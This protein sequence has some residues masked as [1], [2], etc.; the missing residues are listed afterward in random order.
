MTWSSIL[1]FITISALC[2]GLGFICGRIGAAGERAR[3]LANETADQK[4]AITALQAELQL[5]WQQLRDQQRK[6]AADQAKQRD[7]EQ[8]LATARAETRVVY[9]T[10]RK[11]IP[12]ASIDV[13][14]TVSPGLAGA[15]SCQFGSDF[16][17]VWDD[18][19]DPSRVSA[20][21]AGL[22]GTAGVT[23]A[24]PGGADPAVALDAEQLLS[25]HVDNAE[26]STEARDA[27]NALIDWHLEHDLQ[28]LAP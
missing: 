14:A 24:P 6:A 7:L 25:N 12:N 15:G 11:E 10:I 2:L 21:A 9:R 13:A 18:A 22:P 23:A 17:R 16:V 19:S 8:Q 26:L 5:A 4:Q 1:R 20:G 3:C 28:G 27:L